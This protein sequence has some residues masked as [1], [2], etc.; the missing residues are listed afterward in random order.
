MEMRLAGKPRL[1]GKANWLSGGHLI[2][3]LHHG[4]V[5]LQM[6]VFGKGAVGVLDDDEIREGPKASV[7][8]ADVRIL[9]HAYDAPV[10]RRANDHTLGD[11]PIDRI[12]AA[13]TDIVAKRSARSLHDHV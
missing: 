7:R 4:A 3:D 5:F 6:D 13:G 12:L 2:A 1:P 10:P 11:R 9:P 8:T